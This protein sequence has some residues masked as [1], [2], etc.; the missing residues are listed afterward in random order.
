[1]G[2]DCEKAERLHNPVTAIIMAIVMIFFFILNNLLS[3]FEDMNKRLIFTIF[4][5]LKISQ[6]VHFCFV[7]IRRI[8][9][10][11]RYLCLC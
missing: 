6:S 8:I 10:E 11:F 9:A 4:S 5:E 2:W 1:M 3:R 7:Q